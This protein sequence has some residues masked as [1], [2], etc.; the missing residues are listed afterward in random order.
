MYS[1]FC[2]GMHKL[3]KQNFKKAI[4]SHWHVHIPRK[5]NLT[6]DRGLNYKE[7]LIVMPVVSYDPILTKIIK[8]AKAFA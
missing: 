2:A 5:N 4:Y 3:C 6:K 1:L 7:L 8:A